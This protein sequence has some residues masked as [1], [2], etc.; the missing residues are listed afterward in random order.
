MTRSWHVSDSSRDCRWGAAPGL[1]EPQRLTLV[2]PYGIAVAALLVL[3]VFSQRIPGDA[4]R[5][6]RGWQYTWDDLT[7]DEVV[8][9]AGG[10]NDIDYP[11][12]PPGRDG[13]SFVWF[14]REL[15]RSP[16]GHRT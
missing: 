15:P 16:A 8:A 10:W 11:S 6:D 1:Y 4:I 12:N 14:R 2:L 5:L 9:G 13:R 7:V 3:I